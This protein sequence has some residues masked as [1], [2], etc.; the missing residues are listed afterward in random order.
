MAFT[1]VEGFAEPVSQ[2]VTVAAGQT[3]TVTGTFVQ[4]GSLRATTSPAVAG[5]VSVDGVPRNNWGMWT[6]VPVGSHQVCFGAVAGFTAPA[7]Q[8]TVV[9]AG[10]LSTVTGTYVVNAGAPGPSGVGQLRVT[11][12]PALPA[13]ILVDGV[14]RDSWGLTWLSLSPGQHTVSFTH[15]EGFS[16][17]DPVSVSVVVGQITSVTGVFTKRGSLR[18]VTSPAVGGTVSVD[19][20]PRNNW[21]SVDGRSG[22]HP[23]GVFR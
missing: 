20:V 15:V 4:R 2:N 10:E 5:T 11:T 8:D 23:R 3:T 9:S 1:H 13:Q 22:R 7:C 6:D 16:E 12:S 14:L 21:G 17:P 19:G 18:V